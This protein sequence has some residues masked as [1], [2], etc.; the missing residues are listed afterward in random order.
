MNLT[1][2]KIDYIKLLFEFLCKTEGY[3]T[4]YQ[5]AYMISVLFFNGDI[6][7]AN[8]LCEIVDL[9]ELDDF[10]LDS[11]FNGFIKYVTEHFSRIRLNRRNGN[12]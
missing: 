11:D 5:Y 3:G 9:D 7:Y 1:V 10:I 4:E 2:N 12:K 6:R 8:R